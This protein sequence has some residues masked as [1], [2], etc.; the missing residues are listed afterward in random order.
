MEIPSYYIIDFHAGYSFKLL[1]KRFQLRFNILNV[2]DKDRII[3]AQN[4]DPYNGQTYNSF[5][6]KSAA[7]FFG[8]GRTFN[9]SLK[10]N[11]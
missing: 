1:S 7:V 11:F 6:A 3:N 8:L 9:M 2:L 10:M 4:N 5:D